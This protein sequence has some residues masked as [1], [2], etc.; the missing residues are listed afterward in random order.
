MNV[1]NALSDQDKIYGKSCCVPSDEREPH[2]Q[3]ENTAGQARV[4][5]PLVVDLNQYFD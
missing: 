1:S 3:P 2:S 4:H 5:G